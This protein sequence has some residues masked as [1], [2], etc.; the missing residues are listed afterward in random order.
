MV[1]QHFGFV[2]H[3]FF[4]NDAV[5]PNNAEDSKGEYCLNAL[6]K[7]RMGEYYLNALKKYRKPCSEEEKA[8]MK[9]DSRGQRKA[10]LFGAA[11]S[12]S[13]HASKEVTKVTKMAEM[14]EMTEMTGSR[15]QG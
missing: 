10:G 8:D 2:L 9:C 7:Y 14:T 6:K 4:S 5:F 11:N 1:K 3:K 13:R 15:P 12:L